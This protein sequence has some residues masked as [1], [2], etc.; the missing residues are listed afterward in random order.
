[1]SLSNIKQTKHLKPKLPEAFKRSCLF[2]CQM[3]FEDGPPLPLD[4]RLHRA[5]QPPI[6][7][8]LHDLHRSRMSGNQNWT[9]LIK[10]ES[11]LKA[12]EI[13]DGSNVV[14]LVGPGPSNTDSNP[15]ASEN[16]CQRFLKI[17]HRYHICISIGCNFICFKLNVIDSFTSFLTDKVM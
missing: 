17:F 10:M 14:N 15:A 9:V 13:W 3:R 2:C 16:W 8:P 6:L 7:F 5:L 12:A 4:Q 1:M 11:K